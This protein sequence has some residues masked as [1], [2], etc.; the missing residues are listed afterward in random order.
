MELSQKFR[1]RTHLLSCLALAHH[2]GLFCLAHLGHFAHPANLAKADWFNYL[3][4]WFRGDHICCVLLQLLIGPG[5][6]FSAVVPPE[7]QKDDWHNDEKHAQV[8]A[9]EDWQGDLHH[10]IPAVLLFVEE[11]AGTTAV[12]GTAAELVA[13]V[14]LTVLRVVVAVRGH[15][16]EFSNC[17]II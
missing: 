9:N 13:T 4:G 14:F 10:L 11:G 8:D 6:A 15:L 7:T 17:Y 5:L 12:A 16:D 1:L 3:L 2:L